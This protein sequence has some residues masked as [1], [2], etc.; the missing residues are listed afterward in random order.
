MIMWAMFFYLQPANVKIYDYY[1]PKETFS[2]SYNLSKK[3]KQPKSSED[4]EE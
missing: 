2:T 4:D 3:N 1:D